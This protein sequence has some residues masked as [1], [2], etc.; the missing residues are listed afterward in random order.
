MQLAYFVTK[1]VICISLITYTTTIKAQ[2]ADFYLTQGD[3]YHNKGNYNLAIANYTKAISFGPKKFGRNYMFTSLYR[4]N[5]YVELKQLDSAIM[6]FDMAINLFKANNENIYEAYADRANAFSQKKQYDLAIKDYDTAIS[7]TSYRKQLSDYYFKRGD[8]YTKI[9]QLGLAIQSYTNAILSNSENTM[10]YFQRGTTYEKF[11]RNDET[12]KTYIYD[13]IY[14]DIQDYTKTIGLD[15][16]FISAYEN[17]GHAYQITSQ[18]DLSMQDYTTAISKNPSGRNY[19]NRGYNYSRKKQYDL[20]IQDYT[21]AISLNP[22][23]VTYTLFRFFAYDQNN[24]QDLAIQDITKVISLKPADSGMIFFRGNSYAKSGKYKEAI[25]DFKY[26]LISRPDA[27]SVYISIGSPLVR[28]LHFTEAVSFYDQYKQKKLTSY[29]DSV[30]YKFYSYFITAVTQVANGNMKEALT[31]L[32]IA[33]TQYDGTEVKEETKRAYV[34]ILFLKGYIL[35][36][37]N[38]NEDAK[39]IYEQSLIIN[40]LQP[41]LKEALQRI[42]QKQAVTRNIDNT[43][44]EIELINPSPSRSF[45]IEADNGKTQIIGRA[46][47]ISGIKQIKVNDIIVEKTEED[48]LFISNLVLKSGANSLVITATDKQGNTASKTFTIISTAIAGIASPK[49]N[50]SFAPAETPK[51]YALLIAEEDYDDASIPDLQNPVK[52][53]KELKIILETKYTFSAVNIYTLYNKNRLDI[54]QA[55]VQ[56]CNAL[57]K[58]D[59][60]L[61]FYAG[62]GTSKRN[63]DNTVDGFLIPADAWYKLEASYIKASDIK[64]A[65][66][67][68]EAKH[69]LVIADACFSGAL[70][71][72]LPQDVSKAIKIQYERPSRTAMTSGNLEAVPDNSQ[73]LLYLKQRLDENKEK[74]LSAKELFDSFYKAVYN[75]T[76]T[77][78]LYRAIQ[79]VGDEG[80]EF[81]FIKK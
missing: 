72:D 74:Y 77:A 69:I 80:G 56:Q 65:L 12:R 63:K 47:D 61:I 13:S 15:P 14:L 43:P 37:L 25:E 55:I 76:E 42:Q 44:P 49:T 23:N 16:N 34:D 40:A 27:G 22:N 33:S 19:Y 28:M 45:D 26:Y 75:N 46:K 2:D 4:G 29:Y 59:N 17:R 7:K 71:R 81:I 62:H 52:D 35:E 78:P 57:S 73:F 1:I 30:K 18:Y 60:L 58:N 48:G 54:M 8:L 50:Q 32:D 41:D 68:S 67:N 3:D 66:K 39:V 70:I 5:A 9:A 51:F 24:Q 38:R 21:K 10:A 64:D 31:S 53:A 11:I 20:A 36:T 6:D 79:G